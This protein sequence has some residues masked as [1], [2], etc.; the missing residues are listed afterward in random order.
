MVASC[1]V[2][3][4]TAKAALQGKYLRCLVAAAIPIFITFVIMIASELFL[5]ARAL[6][7]LYGTTSILLFVFLLQ[8]LYLGTLRFFWR[9]FSESTDEPITV[10]HYFSD[11]SLYK[12]A[13]ALV[14]R[15]TFR[16]LV[17]GLLFFAPAI[18][19]SVLSDSRIYD[20]FGMS[21]PNFSSAL[22]IVSGFLKTLG[23]LAVLWVMLKC[24]LAPFLLVAD[25]QMEP[26]E[27][28]HMSK[29]I[30]KGTVFD[31][32]VLIIC[33]IHWILLSLFVLP[34]IFTIP[35]MIS[36][37]LVH[38]RYATARYNRMIQRTEENKVPTFVA[39]M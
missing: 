31:F 28:L 26:D 10:F 32:V 19:T 24:Y 6:Q 39:E 23:A 35:Y 27:A 18:I 34:A 8:P 25:E 29:S 3:K 36:A 11:S 30:S 12:R 21:M 5:Y 7:F 4:K 15:L 20:F 13:L 9:S 33:F 16:L 1:S 38:A 2:I 22:W 17:R 14:F 37:Y